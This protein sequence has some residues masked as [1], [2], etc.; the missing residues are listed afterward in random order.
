MLSRQTSPER[1]LEITRL[2]LWSLVAIVITGAS[3][4]LT[5][6]GLGCSDWP[7]CSADRFVPERELH[8]LVE[9]INR[10]FT[11]AV[12]IAVIVAVLGSLYRSPRRTDLTRLSLG[13]VAGALGQIILGGV[14][15]LSELRPDVVMAHFLLSMV[16]VLNAVVLHHRAGLAD[17]LALIEP[18]GESSQRYH[19]WVRV[20][21]GLTAAAVFAGTIVTAAGPHAGDENVSRLDLELR[22]MAR[23]HAL[24]VLVL[25]AVTI[26]FLVVLSRRLATPGDASELA[27][28]SVLTSVRYFVI[29]LVVQGAIGYTQ[30]FN[31]TPALLVGFHIAGA[32]AVWITAVRMLL[33][34]Q[35]TRR[36]AV[37]AAP[38]FQA[39]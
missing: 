24:I 31:D 27:T 33:V 2:A 38:V 3:V 26:A 17:E 15:V 35:D 8:G 25:V 19:I 13:L 36:L 9:F 29:A 12:S 37:E 16:L 39:T 5:G 34:E 14:T 7:T 32:C 6:S 28:R 23:L 20:I 18:T 30:Y 21:G 4:R 22:D 10:I 11:G 1:Y